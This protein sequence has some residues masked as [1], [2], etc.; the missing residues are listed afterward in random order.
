MSSTIAMFAK[1]HN[2]VLNLDE[3]LDT[4]KRYV[5]TI[6]DN[7]TITTILVS[8]F[9]SQCNDRVSIY[10]NSIESESW[11]DIMKNILNNNETDIIEFHFYNIK[12]KQPFCLSKTRD[13]L[14]EEK[15]S[16]HT[17]YQYHYLYWVLKKY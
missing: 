1:P 3:L 7:Y 6:I 14:I 5:D 13:Q 11:S 4:T 16:I 2:C 17:F 10:I 9:I 8:D 12:T 15:Y